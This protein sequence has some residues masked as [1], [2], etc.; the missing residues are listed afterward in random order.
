MAKRNKIALI[1]GGNIGGTLAHLAGLRDLGNVVILDRGSGVAA[2]KALDLEQ[3][4]TIENFDSGM[5]GT[6]D[7]K[8]LEGSDVVIITAGVP[9]KPGMSRDDLLSVNNEVMETAGKGVKQYCPNAFVIIVTNP[10][11]AMVYAF[12]K[13]SGLPVGQLDT[14]TLKALGVN[15]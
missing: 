1:G 5:S 11:D 7:Y 8:D 2:G 13:A 4:S 15:F 6:S 12:Q 9:R 3:S 10:L 14:Q